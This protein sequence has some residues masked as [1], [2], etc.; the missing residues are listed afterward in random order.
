MCKLVLCFCLWVSQL[1]IECAALAFE[2][3][4]SCVVK[5]LQFDLFH[6][7]VHIQLNIKIAKYSQTQLFIKIDTA[8]LKATMFQAYTVI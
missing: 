3:F 8:V 5:L 6:P 7:I 1:C 2:V 4:T